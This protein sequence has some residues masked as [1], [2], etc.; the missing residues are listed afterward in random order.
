ME[1]PTIIVVE[2]DFIIAMDLNDKLI[3]M[4]YEVV[5]LVATGREAIK[6]CAEYR[7]DLV[8]M[9]IVLKG[10]MDGT[11]AAEKIAS[12]SIP[13]VFVSAYSDE[14]TLK[15]AQKSSPYGYLVKPFTE[16]SLHVIIETALKKH[17]S[18]LKELYDGFTKS[19]VVLD[20]E[21]I[22]KKSHIRILIVE[23]EFIIAMDLKDKLVDM[24]YEVVDVV[25][26]GEKALKSIDEHHPGLILMDFLLK[27]DMDGADLA[28]EIAH[29]HIPIIFLTAYSDEDTMK[30]IVQTSPYGYLI[31]PFKANELHSVIEMAMEKFRT[32]KI[33]KEKL[34]S[35]IQI[36]QKEFKMEKSGVF[37]VTAI[38]GS[39]AIYGIVTRSMSWLMYLLFITAT[40]NLFI[41]LVSLKKRE[42]PVPFSKPPMVSILVPAHNEEMTI[43][44]C[45]RS[46]DQMDYY[47]NGEKNFEI[48]VV[49]DGSTD[50][51]GEILRTLKKEVDCLRI[52]TRKPPHAINGKGYALNDGV[53]IAEGEVLAVFDADGWVAPDFLSLIVPYLNEDKVAGVQARVKM[54]NSNRNI[55]TRMQEVEFSIFGNV[56]LRARDIMGKNAFLGGNGQ[57]TTR[58]VIEEIDGW[59]GFAVTEDLNMSIKLMIQGY[60][61]RFCEEAFVYQEA[62][63]FWKPFFRQRLRWATGNLE[64][65]FVYLAPVID[66]KIPLYKKIDSLQF[67]FFLLLIAFVMLGYIVFILNLGRIYI[68]FLNAPVI[69]GVLS[70]IAFFPGVFLGIYRDKID[71]IRVII[72]GIEYWSY[73]LYLIPLFFAAFLHMVTRKDRKWFKTHHLGEDKEEEDEPSKSDI[74]IPAD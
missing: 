43:E 63:P 16:D 51:T 4:G 37:F 73:C 46:F 28:Q 74:I 50:R 19:E 1:K 26:S 31:K 71:I 48:I 55:L 53:R 23:D 72:R 49:N 17:E 47:S 67:L 56:I 10:D 64:T 69:I 70:T 5:S 62:V 13:V 32:D 52:V 30:K 45:V 39:L 2:D 65:L 7:P 29:L 59:D 20:E 36:K 41:V 44:K 54:Y 14:E 18:D 34:Q 68:T 3:K 24:G 38:I 33:K 40:Y 60:K 61:I 35:T 8:L 6:L 12:L 42:P 9:D 66:A 27:G 22:L 11:E 15:K 25:G 21:T 57:L 58:Q